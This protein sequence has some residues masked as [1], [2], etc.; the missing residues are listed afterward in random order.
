LK[1][2][3]KYV[4]FSKKNPFKDILIK[5]GGVWYSFDKLAD[6]YGIKNVETRNP[7]QIQKIEKQITPEVIENTLEEIDLKVDD[8]EYNNII[9]ELEK[10]YGT[11]R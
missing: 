6:I 2:V 5:I 10:K 7:T 4:K 8:Q 9:K 11:K 1:I 3:Y